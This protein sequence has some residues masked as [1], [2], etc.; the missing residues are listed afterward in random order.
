M[1]FILKPRHYAPQ[2]ISV[3]ALSLYGINAAF[4]ADNLKSPQVRE[5]L[6]Y[7]ADNERAQVN[8]QVKIAEI[9]AP[10]FNEERRAEAIAAEFRRVHLDRVKI[11][12]AGNVLGWR[13]GAS[14]RALVIAAHLDT[15]FPPGTEVKV[16][17]IGSRLNG[18]GLVDD[19]RG[20]AVILSFAEALDQAH[21]QTRHSLLFVADVGEEGVG[22]L[23]GI[24]YLVNEGRYRSQIG[25]FV[26]IDGDGSNCIFNREIGSRRYRV[27]ISG[28]GGHSF[29]NFGRVNPAH[30][31]GRVIALL[32][33]MRVPS[34]PKTTYNV[35][36]IGGGT[37]VNSVPFEAWFEFDMRSE[38]E[39]E[40]L[41]LERAFLSLVYRGVD[42]ENRFRSQSGS[43]LTVDAKQI[44][45]RHAIANVNNAPLVEAMTYAS[46]ALG[47]GRPTLRAGSTDSNAAASAGIPSITVDGGGAAGNLHSLQ[48]WFEPAGSAKGIQKLLLAILRWDS[49]SAD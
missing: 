41:R 20:L 18:P 35:G 46:E 40:L 2:L 13:Q 23:R 22:N 31:V 27:V 3:V 19:S 14:P 47:L 48:E 24:K 44:G 21:I 15:V 25:A 10:P 45:I 30:A 43:R 5:A 16:K 8:L 42:D 12:P 32:A 17:R 37:S 28:P 39:Q 29:L 9:P 26:S 7:I 49:S 4:S 36:R 11:D 1:Q 38:N 33:N 6:R 34:T